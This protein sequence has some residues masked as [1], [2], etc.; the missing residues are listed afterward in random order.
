MYV[1]I[2]VYVRVRVWIG[3]NMFMSIRIHTYTVYVYVCVYGRVRIINVI[4]NVY[5]TYGGMYK[6]GEGGTERDLEGSGKGNQIK[7]EMNN[8][9]YV[10]V[11]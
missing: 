1:Y 6:G 7:S 2:Y 4:H 10:Y 9:M 3:V 11:F 8:Y 5:M